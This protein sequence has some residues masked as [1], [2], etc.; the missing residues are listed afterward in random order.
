MIRVAY[1]PGRLVNH[2]LDIERRFFA[3]S[4]GSRVTLRLSELGSTM[5][6]Q[7]MKVLSANTARL[8]CAAN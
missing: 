6:I 1:G 8:R 3:L 4:Y 7:L 2:V 5:E